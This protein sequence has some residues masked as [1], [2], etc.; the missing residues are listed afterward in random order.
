MLDT[1][2]KKRDMLVLVN[3]HCQ[4]AAEIGRINTR[5]FGQK[6]WRRRP[7]REAI[8]TDPKYLAVELDI[9]LNYKVPLN[10]T[11]AG[12]RLHSTINQKPLGSL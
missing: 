8:K 1:N 12:L 5:V 11:T 4:Q 2:V 3:T 6:F 9:A 7:Q 10:K